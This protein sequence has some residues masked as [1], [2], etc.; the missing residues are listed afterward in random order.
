MTSSAAARESI[1]GDRARIGYTSPPLT[2]E[3]FPYEFYRIVPSG[4]TLVLTTLAI[5]V[6]SKDEVDRSY[7]ISMKAA[8][9]MAAAGVDI[10]VLGGVPINLSKG[11]ANAEQMILDLEA[12]LNVKYHQRVGAGQSRAC[13]LPQG[14]G[15]SALRAERDRSDRGL[16]RPLRLRGA[17]RDRLGQRIQPDRAHSAPRRAR[18]GRKLMREHPDADRSCSPHWLTAESIDAL[19]REFGINVMAAHQAIVWD[20][21]RRCGINDR[22]DGFGRCC[23]SSELSRSVGASRRAQRKREETTMQTTACRTARRRRRPR[24]RRRR[25]AAGGGA[26][27]DRVQ[28]R[29]LRPVNTVLAWYV[30][31][32][33][34]LYAAHGLKV[35]IVNMSGGSRGAAELQAG[36]LDVMHVGLSS[37]IRVNRGGGDLR[38]V[39]SFEQRHSF[40][41]LLR[42][43]GQDRGRPQGGVIGVS[44][45]GSESDSTVT[46]ALA[47]LGLTR[48]D[49]TLKEYGG[50]SRRLAAV[51]A[52]EIQATPINEPIASLARRA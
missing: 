11:Y 6:R 17:R 9:E 51:K 31:R 43:R 42:T 16:R 35:D 30:A 19:E 2:T 29:H 3:I 40:H 52:G 22:I 47:R 24:S 45:F 34:G 37:V 25:I 26:G 50:G 15:G 46:L 41:L 33:A 4:V 14:G 18:D 7:D 1:Y 38:S 20:A 21:L 28:G 49:V 39:G 44:T 27:A 13:R 36:R 12:E 23:G 32:D 48:N 10:V 8:R 5:V